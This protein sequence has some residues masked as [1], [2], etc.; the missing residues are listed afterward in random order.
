[1]HCMKTGKSNEFRLFT[2]LQQSF[3]IYELSWTNAMPAYKA[4]ILKLVELSSGAR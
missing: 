3:T 4:T 1:M 2:A